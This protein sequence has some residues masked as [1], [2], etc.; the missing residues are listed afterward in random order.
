MQGGERAK[1]TVAARG[2]A[3]LQGSW[4]TGEGAAERQE[5]LLAMLLVTEAAMVGVLGADLAQLP[6]AGALPLLPL[7]PARAQ[8]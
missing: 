4:V 2:L 1:L 7:D 3:S 6:M 5:L 8:A